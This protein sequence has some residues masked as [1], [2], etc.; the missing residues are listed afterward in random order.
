MVTSLFLTT[1]VFGKEYNPGV[2]LGQTAAYFYLLPRLCCLLLIKDG[3]ISPTTLIRFSES[4]HI[5]RLVLVLFPGS[6]GSFLC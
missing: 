4:L 6:V 1:V 2:L 5:L 3:Q